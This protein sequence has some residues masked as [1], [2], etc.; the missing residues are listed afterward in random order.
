MKALLLIIIGVI[1]G[2]IGG[3]GMGGGTLLIPLLTIFVGVEQ[4]SAQALNLLA[5]IPMSVVAIAIHIKNKLIDFKQVLPIAIPAV[6]A[7]VGS[8][9]LSKLTG[10]RALSRWFGLFL[11][12]LGIYQLISAIVALVKNI[13]EKRRELLKMPDEV[14]SRHI[15]ATLF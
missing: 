4:H 5:F 3:M 15:S 8:S 7:G 14:D 10:A 6:A 9:V 1:G 12:S 11:V 13:R 2:V